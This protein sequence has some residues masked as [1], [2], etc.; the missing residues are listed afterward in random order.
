MKHHIYRWLVHYNIRVICITV[1]PTDLP[2]RNSGDDDF[3]S[4]TAVLILCTAGI[5]TPPQCCRE[6]FQ[7]CRGHGLLPVTALAKWLDS[8]TDNSCII[9][10]M[11]I[12]NEPTRDIIYKMA[13][14]CSAEIQISLGIPPVWSAW[15]SAQSDQSL[16]SAWRK[17]GSHWA[18]SKDSD[19][20]GRMPSCSESSLGAHIVL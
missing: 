14:L 10:S 19:Q 7:F 9:M 3:P 5:P 18:H 4:I 8:K 15:V 13:W 2:T 12:R 16:L 20:T 11:S 17:L 1:L 6:C